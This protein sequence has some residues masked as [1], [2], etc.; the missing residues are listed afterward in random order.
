MSGGQQN[1]DEQ[2]VAMVTRMNELKEIECPGSTSKKA[3]EDKKPKKKV[4]SEE[5][6]QQVADLKQK[7]EEYKTQCIKEFGMSKKD[8][9]SDPDLMDMEKELQKLEG[10][11]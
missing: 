3:D 5:A 8:L 1:K 7:I 6:M 11:K 9:K 10:G 4:L 2:V